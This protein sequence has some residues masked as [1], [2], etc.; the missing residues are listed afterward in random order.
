MSLTLDASPVIDAA[1]PAS[2]GAAPQP[3]S[4]RA[5]QPEIGIRA[6]LPEIGIR[7]ALPA[8]LPRLPAAPA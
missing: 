5:A 6:A 2:A 4:Q 7:A 8:T 1:P 3:D